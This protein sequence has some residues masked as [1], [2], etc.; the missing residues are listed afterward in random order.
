MSGLDPRLTIVVSLAVL[1]TATP[2]RTFAASVAAPVPPSGQVAIA[3]ELVVLDGVASQS[4][5]PVRAAR[6]LGYVSVAMA[7]AASDHPSSELAVVVAAARVVDR[8]LVTQADAAEAL[9]HRTRRDLITRGVAPPGLEVAER[10]GTH[11]AHRLLERAAGDGADAIR[12]SAPPQIDG[13]WQPTP[14][15]F[16]PP[17]EPTAGSWR[18]W[19]LRRGDVYRPPPPPRPGEHRYAAQVAQVY[20]VAGSLTPE[21]AATATF[22]ADGP[23]TVTPPGHW[24][25]I[26]FDLLRQHRLGLPETTEI[27]A[28]LNT[29]QADAFIACWDAKYAYYSERPVTAIRRDLDPEFLPLLTTPPF[30]SYVSGH[31][32]TSAAAATVLGAFFPSARARLNAWAAEAAVSRLYAGIHFDIDNQAGLHLGRKVGRSALEALGPRGEGRR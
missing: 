29:A 24:N 23:G 1:L 11:L 16:L 27:L 5:N 14:P 21:Q 7:R 2:V 28:A 19:H 22:W 12:Q 20:A 32:T 10:R 15:G 9:V 13:G 3:A 30:P 18:T 8:L 17:L 4:L 25:K 31:S 6:L 26:A